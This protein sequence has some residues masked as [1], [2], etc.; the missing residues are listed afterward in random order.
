MSKLRKLLAEY[1]HW[2]KNWDATPDLR[3]SAH[4]AIL[5]H[6]AELERDAQTMAALRG[7]RIIKSK[8]GKWWAFVLGD[9]YP[10]EYGTDGLP[11]TTPQQALEAAVSKCQVSP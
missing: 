9:A 3:E 2:C 6:V 5:S 7:L 1:G 10:V 11:F 8:G 4:E